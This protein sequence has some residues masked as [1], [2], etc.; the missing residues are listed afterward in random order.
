MVVLLRAV[1]MPIVTLFGFLAVR[2]A[3]RGRFYRFVA[4]G[5]GRFA[6]RGETRATNPANGGNGDQQNQRYDIA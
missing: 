6:P 2:S 3:L 1:V 5:I 4:S